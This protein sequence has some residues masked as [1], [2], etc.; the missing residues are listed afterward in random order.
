MRER[1]LDLIN[2]Q[3]VTKLN[4]ST[5]LKVSIFGV[6]SGPCFPVFG[7]NAGKY[8]QEIAL[9]LDTFQECTLHKIRRLQL[10][11]WRILFCSN[12]PLTKISSLNNFMSIPS[13]C[14]IRIL[15]GYFLLK[16]QLYLK[17]P[18]FET[19]DWC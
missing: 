10:V 12:L 16:E 3:Y 5:A 2:R 15:E 6:I 11:F 18:S 9:Y 8:R 17:V 4:N 13:P 14:L 1:V 7:L 19:F